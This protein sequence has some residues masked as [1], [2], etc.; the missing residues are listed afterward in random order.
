MSKLNQFE[1]AA[2]KSGLVD[3]KAA[4]GEV[5]TFKP[6]SFPLYD[7]AGVTVLVVPALQGARNPRFYHVAVAVCAPSDKF[8]RKLGELLA[9]DRLSM[10]E[11]M[12]VR[13]NDRTMQEVAE[14]MATAVLG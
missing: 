10:G 11:T 13:G 3:L 4:G 5:F 6:D 2:R 12:T 7:E 9:L 1:R 8:R 14:D